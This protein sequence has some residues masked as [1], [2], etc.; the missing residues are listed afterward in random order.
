[1]S[2]TWW[3]ITSMLMVLAGCGPEGYAR[4]DPGGEYVY[5]NPA[6]SPDSKQIAYTRCEIYDREKGRN[7]SS[8]ELFSMT[9]ATREIRQLTRNE[10][11]DGQP[12]WSPDG[13]QIV[14]RREETGGN[15]LRVIEVDGSNDVEIFACPRPCNTPAWSPLG[16]AIAFQMIEAVSTGSVNDA[17]SNLYLMRSDGND[18]RQLTQGA[19]A[20]WRPRWSPDGK[21][22]VFRRAADQPIRVIDVATGQETS[23]ATNNARG[24]DEPIFTP[25]GSGIVFTA[26]GSAQG[27][28]LYHLDRAGG[29]IV[30]L[31]NA[32][33]DY[34]PD[35]KEPDWSPDGKQIVFSAFY[36]KLYLADWEQTRVK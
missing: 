31:L 13:Q 21:Q 6:W 36:E 35:M 12:A 23:Y 30:L 10:L 32:A 33:D 22:V 2:K 7:A 18:L 15:S 34:P 25:D 14:Y 24:P 26:Y 8:C 9:A 3:L 20:V 27:K 5:S 19:Q 28:R 11:Y 17:P 16:E 29:S 4:I 1:M